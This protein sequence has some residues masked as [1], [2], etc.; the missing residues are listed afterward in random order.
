MAAG[1]TVAYFVRVIAVAVV[2][3]ACIACDWPWRHDMVDQPSPAAGQGPRPPA[4][5]A[6]PLGADAPFDP[7]VG[8]TVT[9][10]LPPDRTVIAS[11]RALYDVYCVPCHGASGSGI[12][13]TIAKY[14]PGVA[15]LGSTDVQKHGDGWIYAIITAGTAT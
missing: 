1:V 2:C 10:P 3:F 11:G 12:D 7:I 6:L 13:G 8:E 15:D 9:N 14:F 5:N 4:Q